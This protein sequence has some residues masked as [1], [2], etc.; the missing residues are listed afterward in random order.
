MKSCIHFIRHGITE[1]NVKKWYYGKTDLPL[2]EEGRK[3]LKTLTDEGRYPDPEFADLY[4]SGLLR[5]EETFEIIY[6]EIE[7]KTITNLQEMNFGEFECKSYEELKAL[8]GFITWA[9]DQSGEVA[10]PG[11]DSKKSFIK[12]VS[13]GLKELL[14]YHKLREDAHRDNGKDAVSIVV[15]HGGVISQIMMELFASENKNLWDWIPDPGHGYTVY[16]EESN[17]IK[18]EKI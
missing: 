13:L 16:F 1:G 17:P 6:G 3:L 12:R 11:G 5:T 7:H 8:E 15:C 10:F 14:S 9:D 18:Y 2:A 4:T